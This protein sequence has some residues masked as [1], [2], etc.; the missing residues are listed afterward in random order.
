[1]DALL[2]RYVEWR[3]R[4][5]A[6]QVIVFDGGAEVE[7]TRCFVRGIVTGV[8][9]SFL[10]ISLAAPGSVDPQLLAEAGHRAELVRE[11]N[12][13]ADQAVTVASLCLNTARRMDQTLDE[14]RRT[15]GK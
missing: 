1:M 5:R 9:V 13:R 3:G 7:K 8:A 2:R 15:L 12:A 14:Y 6:A 11:A 10:L 4:T